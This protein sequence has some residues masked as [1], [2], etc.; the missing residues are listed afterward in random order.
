M[1]WMA[2]F[3][4]GCLGNESNNIPFPVNLSAKSFTLYCRVPNN[5][6]YAK[7]TDSTIFTTRLYNDLLLEKSTRI[8]YYIPTSWFHAV[9]RLK[10]GSACLIRT[11]FGFANGVRPKLWLRDVTLTSLTS[12]QFL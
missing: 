8:H 10:T 9:N 5:V 12:L 4:R 2:W 1:L 11:G 6:L 7:T 3:W